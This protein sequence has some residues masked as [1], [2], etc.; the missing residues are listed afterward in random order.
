MQLVGYNYHRL[1]VG[2]HTAQHGEE[3]VGLLRSQH[4]GRLVQYEDVRAAV[5]HLDYFYRLLFR[6]GHGVYFFIGIDD[7][8]VAL[9][10]LG[11]LAARLLEIVFPVLYAENDI[12]GSAEHVHQLEVLMDHSYFIFEGVLRRAYNDLLAVYK[13][14]ALIGVINTRYHIHKGGL[15]ASVFSE[16]GKY[17]TLVYG[18]IHILV[19]CYVTEPLGHTSQ[20]K[21]NIVFHR[22]PPECAFGCFYSGAASGKINSRDRRGSV[23]E[24]PDRSLT[25][26]MI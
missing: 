2:A 5:K 8:A 13:Y 15:A 20:F 16:Y 21:G 3:T 12:L 9:G 23:G 11:D 18:Q 24:N 22:N 10:Y 7:K 14:L 1:A 25:V 26:P 4:G 6:D 19:G 17:L